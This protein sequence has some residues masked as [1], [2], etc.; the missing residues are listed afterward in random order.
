MSPTSSGGRAVGFTLIEV[1]ITVAVIAVLAAIAYPAYSDYVHRARA[2]EAVGLLGSMQPKLEQFFQ[3]NR[4]YAGACL[5]GTV[6]PV[7]STTSFEF[8]CTLASATYTVTAKGVGSMNG[9][10][11]NL[12]QDGSRNTV[13]LGRG[14]VG[15]PATCWITSRGGT[16]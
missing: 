4:T 11:Y 5:P 16:C 8:T 10:E 9:F 15:A 6:A 3:D 12:K 2:A 7:P 13:A 14:W 1:M